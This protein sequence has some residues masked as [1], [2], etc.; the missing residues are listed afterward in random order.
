M[1]DAC[2]ARER[3]RAKAHLHRR[4]ATA[5]L[6][7]RRHPAAYQRNAINRHRTLCRSCQRR[8]DRARSRAGSGR[9]A[10]D[11]ARRRGSRSTGCRASPRISAGC[12]RKSEPAGADQGPLHLRRR[13]ARQDHADG[14]VLRGERRWS[15]SAARISTNSW[16]TCTSA[17]HAVRQRDEARRASRTPIRSGTS[18]TRS[19]RKPGCCASTNSTSPTSPTR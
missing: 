5:Y 12:S 6:T 3:P 11:A 7:R 16:P 14:P 15:A 19:P 18:P 9:R 13:R 4:C 2:A 10:A 17:L 8:R 1:P